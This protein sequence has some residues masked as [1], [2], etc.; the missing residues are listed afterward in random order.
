MCLHNFIL[1]FLIP[2]ANRGRMIITQPTWNIFIL[3]RK[4][5]KKKI[6]YLSCVF[7]STFNF[8]IYKKNY[9]TFLCVV[10]CIWWE[11]FCRWV[12]KFLKNFMAYYNKKNEIFLVR[13][14]ELNKEI[15]I[16]IKKVSSL[17]VN[18][19]LSSKITFILS[20]DF[21]DAKKII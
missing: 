9:S 1:F 4:N 2:R 6:I 7:V 8:V 18:W 11:N 5:N 21:H 17:E 15:I 16:S 13:K 19:R 20:N 3:F 12:L 10:I 14:E